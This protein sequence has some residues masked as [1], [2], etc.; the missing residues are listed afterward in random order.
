MRECYYGFFL[1][2][3]PYKDRKN[4]I[5]YNQIIIANRI[6]CIYLNLYFILYIS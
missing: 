6:I 3:F 4:T 2:L 5:I 1:A